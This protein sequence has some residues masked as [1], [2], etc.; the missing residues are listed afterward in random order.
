MK[1]LAI[2]LKDL[3]RSFRSTFAL[4]F[5]FGVP[6]MVT[7]LFY[8]MFGGM[9][10][11]DGGFD[12][13]RTNVVVANLDQGDAQIGNIGKTVLE[14]FQSEDFAGLMVVTTA[15]DAAAARQKVDAG[16]AGVAVIIPENFSA[17]FSD[18]N[19]EAEIALYQDPT[20][21]LGPSIVQAVL[22]QITDH[23]A[24]IK[25]TV[26]EALKRAEAGE[27]EYD[28]ISP[29]VADYMAAAQP[30]EDT[31]TL[32]EQRAVAAAPQKNPM[33]TMIGSIMAGM[34]IFYAFF[35]G[36]NTANS[37]L[38]EE[39]EGTL[40]RLFTTPTSQAEVLSG[41]FLAVGL[42]VAVQV[43]VLIIAARL[44]FG[45]EWG[46]LPGVALSALAIVCSASTFGILICSMMS[47]TKQGGIVFGGILTVT[48]M[49]GM[50]DVFTGNPGG[51]QFGFLPLL[52]PQGWAERGLLLT[53]NGA[54]IAQV[55]P[56][57]LVL[58]ALSAV[59]F[60]TGVWR[61]QRRYV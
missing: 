33:Q 57:A 25:I 35:T 49:I 51:G 22:R 10:S 11:S 2:A 14:T 32:I 15:G 18:A 31:S 13:P 40:Q 1:S 56:Y 28:Q 8:L 47:S 46:A 37:I 59:F 12:I 6:L 23:L 39:E 21:T 29:M 24:G 48:G 42:T 17:S 45:I 30:G 16:E 41:K 26:A 27:I 9:N 52:T 34:M 61:F 5:M 43:V 3:T 44:I 20:L 7:G 38:S 4:I 55:L 19:A 36:V 54:P 50:V 53:M 58:L 60:I